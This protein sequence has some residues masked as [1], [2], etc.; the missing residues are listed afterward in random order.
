[1]AVGFDDKMK[2]KNTN[3]KGPET[4]GAILIRNS[5]GSTNHP[6]TLADVLGLS[7]K[8]GVLP[9][10]WGT[11]WGEKGYGWLP[12]VTDKLDPSGLTD[13]LCCPK[14]RPIRSTRIGG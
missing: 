4:T 1:M 12:F 13:N 7:R 6:L 5:W 2:I 11:E 10:L 9:L 8:G 3:L 14:D